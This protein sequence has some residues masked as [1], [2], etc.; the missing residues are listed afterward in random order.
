[1]FV[2]D[3][4]QRDLRTKDERE[5]KG[6]NMKQKQFSRLLML[7]MEEDSLIIFS[8]VWLIIIYSFYISMKRC[9]SFVIAGD[10]NGKLNY[11]GKL[12]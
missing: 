7:L 6:N 1:M 9:V 12:V 11:L 3:E 5:N 4:D 10:V 2:L 8:S